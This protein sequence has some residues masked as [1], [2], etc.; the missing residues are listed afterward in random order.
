MMLYKIVRKLFLSLLNPF[1]KM[2]THIL[3]KGNNIHYSTFRTNGTPYIMVA[4]GGVY[5]R[6]RLCHEQ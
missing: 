6:K 4:R 5:N 3:F 1:E 2:T